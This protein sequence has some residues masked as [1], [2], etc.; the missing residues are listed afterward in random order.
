MGDLIGKLLGGG[1]GAA[2]TGLKELIDSVT[3]TKEEKAQADLAF[4]KLQ[5]D[6]NEQDSQHRTIFVAGWR[7]FIGWVCGLALLYNYILRDIINWAV[8]I[9]APQITTMPGLDFSQLSTILLGMLGLG[10]YRTYEKLKGK[11][12]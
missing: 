7:P 1:A 6:I 5:T 2:L 9:W 10:G 4:Y 12:K 8:A 3:T 11:T